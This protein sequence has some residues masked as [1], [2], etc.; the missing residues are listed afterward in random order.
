NHEQY[1]APANYNAPLQTVISGHVSAV[2]TLSERVK[3]L[4]AR[5]IVPLAVS[6][7]FHTPL[8]LTAQSALRSRLKNVLITNPN[9]SIISNVTGQPLSAAEEVKL[10]LEKQIISPVKWE[11]SINFLL[12]AGVDTFV[13]FG[14]GR[15]LIN[16]VRQVTRDVKCY[17]INDSATIETYLKDQ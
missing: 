1:V 6:G 4:G 9:I 8:M 17:A 13:E 16:L 3:E 15:V 10:A 14:T 11:Q 5:R 12:K 2:T 7:P